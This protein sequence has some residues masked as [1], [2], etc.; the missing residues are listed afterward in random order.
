VVKKD[1]WGIEHRARSQE[2]ESRRNTIKKLISS[3]VLATDYFC[4]F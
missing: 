3:Q 4:G 2:S 1:A